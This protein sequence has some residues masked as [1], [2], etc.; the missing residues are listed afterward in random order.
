MSGKN[1]KLFTFFWENGKKTTGSGKDAKDAFVNSGYPVAHYKHVAH[2]V[3]GKA[4]VY[5]WNCV[6]RSWEAL[7]SEAA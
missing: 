1:K 6:T 5:R 3:E 7:E 2:V 4:D